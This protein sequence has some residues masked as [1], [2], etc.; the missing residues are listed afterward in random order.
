MDHY[1]FLFAAVKQWGRLVVIN[2]THLWI[3][4][5][6]STCLI[7]PITTVIGPEVQFDQIVHVVVSCLDSADE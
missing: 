5:T 3:R 4:D 2:L 6:V 7:P 1:L